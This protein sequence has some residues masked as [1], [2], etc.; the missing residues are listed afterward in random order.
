MGISF[1]PLDG[2]S[3]NLSP[4]RVL[5]FV[6]ASC[7]HCTADSLCALIVLVVS[8]RGCCFFVVFFVFARKTLGLLEGVRVEVVA[9]L[10]ASLSCCCR[11]SVLLCLFLFFSGG[12]MFLC[13]FSSL[14]LVLL[15][16]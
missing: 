3:S 12:A 4:A 7:L 6:F 10:S 14:L 15:V 11:C 2:H 1:P 13:F 9:F 8:L 5:H 16:E